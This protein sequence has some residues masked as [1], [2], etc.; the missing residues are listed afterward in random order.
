MEPRE[1]AFVLGRGGGERV[2]QRLPVL[3]TDL[4]GCTEGRLA[5]LHAGGAFGEARDG[6]AG[7]H[8]EAR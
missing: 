2:Q 7:S 1:V 4:L 3:E 6:T 8:G 5:E